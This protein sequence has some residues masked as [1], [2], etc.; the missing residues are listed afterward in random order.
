MARQNKL[1]KAAID[2]AQEAC[3]D[4]LPQIY[5]TGLDILKTAL[6]D[7]IWGEDIKSKDINSAIRHFVPQLIEKISELNFKVKDSSL[8][9]LVKWFENQNADIL[10]YE[11]EIKLNLF[12]IKDNLCIN[13]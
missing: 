10:K 13:K 8:I 7:P 12:F 5:H 6:S 4:K 1:F 11:K 3:K 9:T 2:V